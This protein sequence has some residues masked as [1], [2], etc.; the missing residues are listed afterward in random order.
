M[1]THILVGCMYARV[2]LYSLYL[3]E[4]TLHIGWDTLAAG[5]ARRI[6]CTVDPKRVQIPE[7][8]CGFFR[9]SLRGRY[10]GPFSRVEL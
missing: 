6:G 9:G 7:P 3:N 8:V 2:T 1:C 5:G 4:K 10:G